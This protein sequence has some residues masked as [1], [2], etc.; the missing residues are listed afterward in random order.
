[1]S[2]IETEELNKALKELQAEIMKKKELERQ[3]VICVPGTNCA[4]FNLK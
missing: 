1:M 2:L 4:Y 3:F